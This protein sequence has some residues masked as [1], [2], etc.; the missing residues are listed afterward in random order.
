[1]VLYTPYI[2][3]IA[4][5]TKEAKLKYSLH[6]SKGLTLET[7]MTGFPQELDVLEL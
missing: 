6:I 2:T 4:R 1:L 3:S 7:E 5:K